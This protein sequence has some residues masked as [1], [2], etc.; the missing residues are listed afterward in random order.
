MAQ[1]HPH[2]RCQSELGITCAPDPLALNLRF[3]VPSWGCRWL[4]QLTEGRDTLY[5][6]LLIHYKGRSSDWPNGGDAQAGTGRCRSF[7]ALSG[8]IALLHLLM[9]TNTQAAP[10]CP[11]FTEASLCRHD[12]PLVF[13]SIFSPS[14]LPGGWGG[15]GL[16]F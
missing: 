9:A 5:L 4:E 16:K 6:H 1:D 11:V 13:H 3:Y 7:R 10:T 8:C 15:V 12:G 2:F 14:S